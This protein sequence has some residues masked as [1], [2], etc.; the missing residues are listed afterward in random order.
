MSILTRELELE[1][2]LPKPNATPRLS[3]EVLNEI[4]DELNRYRSSGAPAPKDLLFSAADAIGALQ[5]DAI[6]RERELSALLRQRE[7]PRGDSILEIDK[8]GIVHDA[9][10]QPVEVA[11]ALHLVKRS[12]ASHSGS[13]FADDML[14]VASVIESLSA[15]VAELYE[16]WPMGLE[17]IEASIAGHKQLIVAAEQRAEA[18]EKALA[19]AKEQIAQDVCPDL[20]LELEETKRALAD[21]EAKRV[22]AEKDAERYLFLR[23]FLDPKDYYSKFPRWTVALESGGMGQV[24]HGEK[25]D[26]AID[27]RMEKPNA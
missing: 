8:D 20:S 7:Q 5:F 18:A 11:E 12:A 16:C 4:K 13:N 17:E 14:K 21:S 1:G 6:D 26:A 22:A 23:N 2:N 27:A 15:Q 19:E 25:L 3:N 9:S 10:K 24:Y